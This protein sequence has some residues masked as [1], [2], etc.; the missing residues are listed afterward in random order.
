MG[1]GLIA[2]RNLFIYNLGFP[3]FG[4]RVE[5]KIF[6]WSASNCWENWGTYVWIL[7]F[8]MFIRKRVRNLKITLATSDS[9]ILVY[10][11]SVFGHLSMG[12]SLKE[13]IFFADF[14]FPMFWSLCFQKILFFFPNYYF[15][16]FQR[17]SEN[18]YYS[19]FWPFP[20]FSKLFSI[21]T[22]ISQC[23]V[24]FFKK[25]DISFLIIH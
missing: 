14:D 10:F 11:F 8:G 13:I 6:N 20:T 3:S 2:F 25:K 9:F 7:K 15:L 24:F 21:K 17:G 22:K 4:A 23:K 16:N 1:S 18:V 19:L 5:Q 12:M